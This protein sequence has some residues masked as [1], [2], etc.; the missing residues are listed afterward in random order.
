M[1]AWEIRQRQI[2]EQEQQEQLEKQLKIKKMIKVSL[3]AT[4]G[5]ILLVLL[6]NS[7]ERIDAGHVGVKVNQY[8]DNKGVDDVTAVT[9][10]YSIIQLQL[11]FMNSL[12][13][14]N[15]KNTKV[16]IHL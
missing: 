8:G 16:R 2:R 13:S 5:F 12:H 6:F 14:F 11:V 1:D 7:C 15:T 4:I 10:M 3:S 9:G